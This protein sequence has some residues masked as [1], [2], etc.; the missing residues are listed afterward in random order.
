MRINYLIATTTSLLLVYRTSNHL[1][2][3]RILLKDGSVYYP[4]ELYPYSFTALKVAEQR[5]LYGF[6]GL[7]V[8][9]IVK[10]V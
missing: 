1:Y 9:K 10:Q 3:Y 8:V 7:V 4:Q 2:S 6:Q 5:A